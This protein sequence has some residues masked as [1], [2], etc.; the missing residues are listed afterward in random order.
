MAMVLAGAASAQD[1]DIVT[2]E[3]DD[4][5]VYEGTFKDGKQHGTGSHSP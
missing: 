4:G 1:G 3:Y 2:K 5:G